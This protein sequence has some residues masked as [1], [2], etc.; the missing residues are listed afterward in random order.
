MT[1][2]STLKRV[3]PFGT[4]LTLGQLAWTV[5][6]HWLAIPSEHRDR[7]ADLLRKSRGKPSNLSRSERRELRELVRR[8]NLTRL[9]RDG[10]MSATALRQIR[11]SS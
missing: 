7:L 8:L 6:A 2:R 10:A 9:L 1:L 3:G 4:A 11:R 5:R